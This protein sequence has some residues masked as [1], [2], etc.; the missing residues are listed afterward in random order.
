MPCRPRRSSGPGSRNTSS[1]ET[2]S[3]ETSSSSTAGAIDSSTS[4]RTGG[5][6]RRR[7]SSFSSA[8][9]RFSASSS[10][11]SRSSLRVTRNV[12]DSRTSMP[13][14]SR[15]RC[16]AI[17][18]SSG[19]NRALRQRDEALEDRRHLHPREVLLAGLGVA[20]QH[21]EVEREPGDVGERV[22][23]VD[24]ERGEHREDPVA[25]EPLALLLLVAVQVGPAHQLDVLS[26]Q[27]GHDLLA[28][29]P[30][31]PAG[32]AR[33]SPSRWPRGPRAAAAPRPRGPPRPAAIRRFSP[34]TLTMKNS[35][36][37]LVKMARNRTRSS[38]GSAGSSASSRTRW[39]KR[40]HE[41]SRSRKRSSYFSTAASASS[42][43]TYGAGTTNVSSGTPSRSSASAGTISSDMQ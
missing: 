21:R 43:G 7:S 34:A 23:G 19:T 39:L 10:S 25:E 22:G 6:N 27:R 36:R 1:S 16:S 35:S 26:L 31:V 20:D 41:S 15:F 17:T 32:S 28:E 33:G 29:Q 12:C 40:S 5:P 9:R 2:S 13:G 38:S 37:L 3:S 42:S 4:S 24:G 8:A 30:R 11:T 18:S 14:N